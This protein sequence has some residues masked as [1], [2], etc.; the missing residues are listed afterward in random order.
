MTEK[1]DFTP[2]EA[3]AALLTEVRQC[4]HKLGEIASW[5]AFG[6]VVLFLALALTMC[7]ALMGM[8]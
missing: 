8:G 3:L 2:E 5:V 1:T 7:N 6:G 4:R